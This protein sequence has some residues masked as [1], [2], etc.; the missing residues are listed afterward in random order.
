MAHDRGVFE[1]HE[2]AADVFERHVVEIGQ[3]REGR[4]ESGER[5]AVGG[6]GVELDAV[7]GREEDGL[8]LGVVGA[9]GGER[10]GGLRSG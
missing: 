3:V 1:R 7:A 10:V 8:G 4:F 9:P 5:V 6:G 2:V